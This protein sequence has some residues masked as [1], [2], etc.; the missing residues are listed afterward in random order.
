MVEAMDLN[1]TLL[2]LQHTLISVGVNMNQ[3]YLH[4]RFPTMQLIRILTI[5]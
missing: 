1:I 3:S 5:I 4:S 2:Y